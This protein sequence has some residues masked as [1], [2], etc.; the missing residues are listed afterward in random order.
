MVSSPTLSRRDMIL[1]SGILV[2]GITQ[3]NSAL[4]QD[5]EKDLIFRTT[6]PRNAEPALNKLIESWITPT[7]HFYVRSHAPNPK[8]D[9]STFRLSVEGLVAKP[10]SLSLA[11]IKA[12]QEHTITATLTCAGNRRAE[13]NKEGKVGGVQWDAGAI[14]NATWTG[15]ALGD[16]L[17]KAGI[18]TGAKHVWFEGLDEIAKGDGIIPFGASIPI[19]KATGDGDDVGALLCYGMNGSELTADHGYPLRTLV[20]GYIGA[21]S[22]KW[23]GKIVVSDVTSPN[24]YLATAYKLVKK[25]DA[26]DW[27]EAG[28]IYRYLINAAVGSHEKGAKLETGPVDLAGYVLPSGI[29]GAE[30]KNVQVS[31]DGGKTWQKAELTG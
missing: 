2:A 15:V 19:E 23:L 5:D 16:V 21:R 14:G 7:K 17:K 29:L 12:H 1:T 10:L 24:H 9:P 4:G 30:V 22:V 27:S 13:Y 26:I 8:I 20:P 28:P 31:A 25:T 3:T 11:D 6:D 18:K